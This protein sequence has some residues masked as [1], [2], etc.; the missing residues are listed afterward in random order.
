MIRRA[1]LALV[2]AAVAL[3]G[4][5]TLTAIGDKIPFVNNKKNASTATAGQ[6]VSVIA[7][8]DKLATAEGLKGADFQLPEPVDRADWPL[9]GGTPEQ[10]VENV[11][12]AP[13][14]EIAWKRDFGKGA[15]RGSQVTSPPIAAGGKIFVMDGEATVSAIDAASGDVI[16]K[17]DLRPEAGR[18]GKRLFGIGFGGKGDRTG[19]G[20]GVAYADGKLYVASGF[21]FV[22]QLDATTGKVGWTS[23]VQS[24]LHA[25]P[26]VADGRVFAMSIDNEL[27]TF[28]AATG[29]AGWSYQALIEPSRILR[30]SS[31]AI[32]GDTIVAGFGSG[33]LIALRTGNGNE[34]WTE[35][36]SRA[37][38][39]N[40]L[41]EI[42]DIP[43]RPVI[44][45]GD[46]FAMSHS[47]ILSATDLRT[48]QARWTLPIIGITSPLPAGDVVFIVS[49][50]GEVI[51]ASRENAQIYWIRE[52]NPTEGMS[53]RQLKRY[54]KHPVLWSTP[55]LAN[56]RLILT[57]SNGRLL[58]LNAKTGEIQKELKLGGPGLMGPIAVGGKV[59]IATD[60]A[61][62][63]ALR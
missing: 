53:K 36:L 13:A 30:A 50:A 22:A 32:S 56:G 19:F 44:Y 46:V 54:Q 55:V 41:S 61:Q 10:S 57:S 33:E 21:R 27:L 29:A 59:F 4:C 60:E 34:L 8:D 15:K 23:P 43:G 3:S 14:F 17:R 47:G 42:R 39:N 52:L 51:C 28:D 16:W 12:A 9:P 31:P 63:V 24:P 26:T 49:K 2:I 48:G 7:F 1:S 5:S 18:V 45:R 20:G 35:A 6:R 25:A 40:A 62:L 11:A 58:A 38:R 37:N